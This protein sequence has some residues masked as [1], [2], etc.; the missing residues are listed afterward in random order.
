LPCGRSGRP[1]ANV[2]STTPDVAAIGEGH[3]SL[4]AEQAS[5]LTISAVACEADRLTALGNMSPR[6]HMQAGQVCR[7]CRGLNR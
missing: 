1:D 3:R 2:K 7:A 6:T 4:G 5:R